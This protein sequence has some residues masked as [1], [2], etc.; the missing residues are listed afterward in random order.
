MNL[1]GICPACHRKLHFIENNKKE[2]LY[3]SL[4]QNNN[5]NKPIIERIKILMDENAIEPI[6][7]DFLKSEFI[8]THDE[9]ND[10]MNEGYMVA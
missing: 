10:L 5:L 2:D 4:S 9:Y 1:F 3:T 8:I 6:H 7:L